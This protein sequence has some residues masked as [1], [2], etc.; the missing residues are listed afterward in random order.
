MK[1]GTFYVICGD[2]I[3]TDLFLGVEDDKSKILATVQK[4]LVNYKDEIELTIEHA[5][6]IFDNVKRGLEEKEQTVVLIHLESIDIDGKHVDNIG[7][8]PPYINKSIR[9]IGD[10][11]RWYPLYE[12][13]DH[14]GIVVDYDENY[15]IL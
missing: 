1:S 10:G 4:V 3:D 14:L 9:M 7:D 2:R 13:L 5:G 8:V 15:F 11:E 12:I 6:E